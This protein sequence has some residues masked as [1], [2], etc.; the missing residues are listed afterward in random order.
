MFELKSILSRDGNTMEERIAKPDNFRACYEFS[1]MTSEMSIML[2]R[3]MGSLCKEM[4]FMA[5]VEGCTHSKVAVM[6]D[7]KHI[8]CHHPNFMLNLAPPIC[9][10]L[11]NSGECPCGCRIKEHE[12]IG[13]YNP[14][15]R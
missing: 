10:W 1:G 11:V 6:D 8:T 7:V 13:I 5:I 4:R 14:R 9:R 12:T 15:E 3:S 2:V